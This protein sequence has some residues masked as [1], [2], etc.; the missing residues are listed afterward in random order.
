MD[1]K[2]KVR[3]KN[4]KYQGVAITCAPNL[5]L[6]QL[7]ERKNRKTTRYAHLDMTRSSLSDER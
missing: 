4:Q 2:K 1:T 5:H 7:R 3:A 6:L